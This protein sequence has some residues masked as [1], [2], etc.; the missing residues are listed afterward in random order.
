MVCALTGRA[1]VILAISLHPSIN[2]GGFKPPYKF[3]LGQQWVCTPTY[4]SKAG[5]HKTIFTYTI[6]IL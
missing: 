2:I 5:T 6:K 4:K 3:L 1:V